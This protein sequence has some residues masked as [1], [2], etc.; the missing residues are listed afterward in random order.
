MPKLDERNKTNIDKTTTMRKKNVLAILFITTIFCL[1]APIADAKKNSWIGDLKGG[2]R[3]QK[4]QKL[5]WENGIS[6]D[7][8]SP[9]ILDRRFHLG[10]SYVTSRLGSAMGSNAIRQDNYLLS[11]AYHF[12]PK[13]QLQPYTRLNIGYFHADYEEAIFD[14]LPNSAILLSIDAGLS[15]DFNAPFALSLSTGYNVNTGNGTSGPG[16]LYPVFYQMSIYY[17]ISKRK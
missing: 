4:T 2:I 15:Y 10:A 13:K 6:F 5:Y 9:R 8:N 14:V 16:T 12:R 17:T 11:S 3:I 7:V 1:Q